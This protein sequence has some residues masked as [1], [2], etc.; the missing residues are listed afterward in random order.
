MAS[1]T[2]N[3]RA[4]NFFQIQAAR[5]KASTLGITAKNAKAE[6]PL[7]KEKNISVMVK[8]LLYLSNSWKNLHSVGVYFIPPSV[9]P[10]SLYTFFF[11][12]LNVSK[13]WLEWNLMKSTGENIC[14]DE[15]RKLVKIK[16]LKVEVFF[17]QNVEKKCRGK[18]RKL[19]EYSE[20][21]V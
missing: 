5:V 10:F 6:K 14:V 7:G 12:I 15:M 3:S 16:S 17:S 1:S 2:T 13:F 4:P 19:S 20:T 11:F 21:L 18:K 9:V 8:I